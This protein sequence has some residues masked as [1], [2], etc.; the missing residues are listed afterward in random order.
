MGLIAGVIE[1]VAPPEVTNRGCGAGE[2]CVLFGTKPV[3]TRRNRGNSG[4]LR[5]AS[6]YGLRTEV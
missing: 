1:S 5:G 2:G 6:L 3:S 4:D